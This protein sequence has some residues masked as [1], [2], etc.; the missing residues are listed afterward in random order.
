MLELSS[1]GR[2]VG[3][4]VHFPHCIR[5]RRWEGEARKTFFS[6]EMIFNSD[7]AKIPPMP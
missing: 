1:A 3:N 5:E 7:E 6:R 4:D 2:V